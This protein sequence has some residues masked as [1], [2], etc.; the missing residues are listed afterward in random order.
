MNGS[1]VSQQ[2]LFGVDELSVKRTI[3]ISYMLCLKAQSV[4]ECERIISAET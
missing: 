3:R 1:A 4:T 2:Q